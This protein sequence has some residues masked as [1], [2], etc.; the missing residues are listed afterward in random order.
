MNDFL[1]FRES[2]FIFLFQ[3]SIHLPSIEFILT[4]FDLNSSNNNEELLEEIAAND[5]I[6]V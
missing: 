3:G 6:I 4:H 1:G 5:E 2:D